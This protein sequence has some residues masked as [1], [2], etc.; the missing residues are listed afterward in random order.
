MGFATAGC[1]ISQGLRFRATP[2]SIGFVA[3]VHPN[4][5]YG[6]HGVRL[7]SVSVGLVES[8]VAL[9]RTTSVRWAGAITHYAGVVVRW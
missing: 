5:P 7:Q 1:R 3:V 4:K 8:G 2:F 6:L 9:P